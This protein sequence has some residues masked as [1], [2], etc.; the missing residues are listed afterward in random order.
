MGER[1]AVNCVLHLGKGTTRGGPERRN[2]RSHARR[3]DVDS[4]RMCG[5][6]K[7]SPRPS[8]AAGIPPQK[9]FTAQSKPENNRIDTD[10]LLPPNQ[11][12]PSEQIL[13]TTLDISTK[14]HAEGRSKMVA[15]TPSCGVNHSIFTGRDKSHFCILLSQ[16]LP[17]I[18]WNGN[19]P[20]AGACRPRRAVTWIPFDKPRTTASDC[21][22]QTTGSGSC[23]SGSG[24]VL[25]YYFTCEV[26]I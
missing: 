26:S 14:L 22:S 23:T 11:I 1:L 6:T 3:F 12:S 7:R 4:R 16:H 25:R 13:D 2:A 20:R 18:Q 8:E 24:G 21:Q 17:A 19:H 10:R 5:D 15:D 9:V